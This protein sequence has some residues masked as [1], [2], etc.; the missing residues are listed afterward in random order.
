MAWS[1][2]FTSCLKDFHY[3][4]QLPQMLHFP[5]PPALTPPFPKAPIYHFPL[6]QSQHQN[7]SPKSLDLHG[8]KA[9]RMGAVFSL[10]S[11]TARKRG[12]QASKWGLS[13]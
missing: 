5:C 2:C 13:I 7:R 3:P 12:P 8:E 11:H 9:G 6:E 10:G 1:L 4:S